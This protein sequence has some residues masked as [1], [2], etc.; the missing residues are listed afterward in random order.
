MKSAVIPIKDNIDKLLVC[1][2]NDI[3]HI[4]QNLSQLNELRTLIIKRDDAALVKLLENIQKM[5]EIYQENESNRLS[6]RKELADALGYTC[7]QVTLSVLEAKLP[8]TERCQITER[9][10]KL[11]SLIEKLKKEHL[12]T[13]MLLSECARFNNIILKNIFNFGRT[14]IISYDSKGETKRQ[15]ETA[16]MNLKL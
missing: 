8:E 5:S 12:S 9:K 2:D 13:T 10:I 7:E 6:I 1:L 4:E 16:F 14:E 15:T 11:K 3:L